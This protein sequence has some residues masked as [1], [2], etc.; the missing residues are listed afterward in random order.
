MSYT[1]G[2]TFKYS[3][4]DKFIVI[5]AVWT[6]RQQMPQEIESQTHNYFKT[7]N[8]IGP[9]TKLTGT[10][11]AGGGRGLISRAERLKFL[12]FFAIDRLDGTCRSY[13]RYVKKYTPVFI[14]MKRCFDI[15]LFITC[16][17]VKLGVYNTSQDVKEN[18]TPEAK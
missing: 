10:H 12:V 2:L 8:E 13:C 6:Q 15:Y 16:Y 14:L 1:S 3:K 18:Q 7:I 4:H 5:T 17:D 9:R 11:P